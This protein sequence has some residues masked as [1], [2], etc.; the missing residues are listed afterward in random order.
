VFSEKNTHD[1]KDD[2]SSWL[3]E[4]EDQMKRRQIDII[5]VLAVA[6]YAAG[7]AGCDLGVARA[8]GELSGGACTFDRTKG[9]YGFTCSGSSNLGQGLV[10][11]AVVG[12]VSGDAAGIF[13][14]RG[15][16]NTPHGSQPW[17][18][19][20]PAT[21]DPDCFGRVTFDTN[22]IEVPSGSGNWVKLPP[23]MFDFAVVGEG[24]EILGSLVAPGAAGEAVPRVTCRLVRVGRRR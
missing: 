24:S 23:D 19:K 11:V 21:M 12:V 17:R 9:A 5:K 22:E 10:P 7:S 14:G 20:G 1:R 2:A 15:T 8:E 6:G 13:T 3:G 18:F 4:T 16:L